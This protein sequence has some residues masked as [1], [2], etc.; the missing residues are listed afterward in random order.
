MSDAGTNGDSLHCL[1]RLW[2]V[3]EEDRGMGTT[4]CSCHASEEDANKHCSGH[5]FA[6]PVDVPWSVLESL[7]P[8]EN[9]TGKQRPEKEGEHV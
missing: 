7:K 9:L 6:D 1:V 3:V 8:N 2:V 5:K 4:I